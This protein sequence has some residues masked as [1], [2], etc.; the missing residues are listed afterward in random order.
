MWESAPWLGIGPGNYSVVYGNFNLPLWT[1][2]L[3]HAHNLYINI[4]AETGLIGFA[5]FV[6]MWVSFAVWILK[7]RC[8]ATDAPGSKWCKAMAAGA[9]GSMVYVSIHSIVDVLFV[10]GIYLALALLFATLAAGC[11]GV[12]TG[13]V[14]SSEVQRT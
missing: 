2:P 3:G 1:E 14:S 13:T 10:Q 8:A 6:L 5:A 4:L 7:F 9:F 11:T 12:S